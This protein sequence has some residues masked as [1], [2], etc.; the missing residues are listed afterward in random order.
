M[1]LVEPTGTDFLAMNIH[2][3]HG[4]DCNVGGAIVFIIDATY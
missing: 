3:L 4:C 1:G 2:A